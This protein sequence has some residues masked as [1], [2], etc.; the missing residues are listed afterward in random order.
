MVRSG[1]VA[2]VHLLLGTAAHG[3]TTAAAARPRGADLP[4]GGASVVV[5][6]DLS[7]EN[8]EGSDLCPARGTTNHHDLSP[9]RGV[10][11]DLMTGN[12][13]RCLRR[14][15]RSDMLENFGET[16]YCPC[17]FCFFIMF[18]LAVLSPSVA[19]VMSVLCDGTPSHLFLRLVLFVFLM[20][21]VIGPAA[22]RASVWFICAIRSKAMEWQHHGSCARNQGRLSFL[23]LF[24]F[25]L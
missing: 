1:L 11:P 25:P 14:K 18:I 15:P 22:L 9:G 12:E 19:A 2:G 24:F 10:V 7:P 6:A 20:T 4:G 17:K 13:R 8:A 16:V 21:I 5:A 23:C 3:M